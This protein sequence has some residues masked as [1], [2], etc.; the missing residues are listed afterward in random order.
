MSR[1]NLGSRETD[2]GA[3]TLVAGDATW[4]SG[5]TRPATADDQS[6]DGHQM[7]LLIGLLRASGRWLAIATG[8]T[9]LG[10]AIGIVQP[11]LVKDIVD[12][13]TG[14][15]VP[16]TY[17]AAL[18]ILFFS[19]AAIGAL[20]QYLLARTGQG[21]LLD[22]RIRMVGRLM[23]LHISVY[24][25]QRI[26]DLIS[27]ASADTT[28]VREAV[29]FSISA[30]FTGTLGAAA[31]IAL[32]IWLDP[33]LFLLVL[34]AV[35]VA[36]IFM[37]ITL[38]RVRVASERT[39]KSVGGMA[40]D[41]ERALAAIRTIRA[42]RAEGRE[43]DRINGH[44]REAYRAGL[45]M[46]KLDSLIEPAAALAV[47]GSILLVLMIGGLR[48]ANGSTELG[49]LV[50]F[51]L[52]A[53]YLMM[54]LSEL[55]EA[56]G[57]LQQG[58][59]AMARVSRI[60]DLPYEE[61]EVG[62]TEGSRTRR[63][64]G[65][66][67]SPVLVR[68]LGVASARS[69]TV[70]SCPVPSSLPPAIEFRDVSF[71]YAGNSV[72]RDISFS[73]P[74]RSHFAL[75]G[76]SGVGKSTVFALMERFYDPDIGRIFFGGQDVRELDRATARTWVNLVEQQAPVLHGTI[77]DNIAYAVPSATEED[78]RCAV[79]TAGL[80]DLVARLPD[81]LD[82]DVGDHGV[83]LSG[84]ER[85]RIAIGRALLARP[86]VLLLD[87]PT[88]QLD[89]PSERALTDALG[90]LTHGSALLVIAHRLSTVRA[91]EKILVMDEGSIVAAGS[92]EDLSRTCRVYR[93]L[94]WQP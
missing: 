10:T 26:G 65:C 76:R 66:P 58:M 1:V 40:A 53:T 70:P 5:D 18:F 12:M 93:Q 72:L 74:F 52:Y 44:A 94:S 49:D 77:R 34:A 54:P 51:L 69:D 45:R 25:R 90:E 62:P 6:A 86:A 80:R 91:A 13:A 57:V 30:F 7:R 31:A 9:A 41:L 67:G 81:G 14:G 63:P 46:A 59:G 32:M 43:A 33:V 38:G 71:A 92:H 2:R 56:A 15:S 27:R 4:E 28:V 61:D 68:E 36:S 78:I 50:A 73:V 22:L 23:R 75:V 21:V 3:S 79:R 24:D 35:T 55:F 16:G 88:S 60:F 47:Q 48:V 85:Q 20:G 89:G 37:S 83:L 19:Q 87:E 8:V 17:I 11:L 84:G 29:A 64:D 82:T 39:Q 42:N